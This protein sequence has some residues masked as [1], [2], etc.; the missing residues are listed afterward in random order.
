MPQ[1]SIRRVVWY[2]VN[3]RLTLSGDHAL[4]QP[5]SE[6]LNTG[7]LLKKIIAL[8][9]KARRKGLAGLNANKSDLVRLGMECA[10]SGNAV[11]NSYGVFHLAWLAA[12][13]SNWPA[14]VQCE[15]DEI[16]L[17]LKQTHGARLRFLIWAGM[18]GSAEDKSA[19]VAAGLLNKGPK[20]FVL[21]STDPAKLKA[22]LAGIE[23]RAGSLETGLKSTLV[24][25]MA[26]GMTSFEPVFNLERL[27]ALYDKLGIVSTP[28]FVY[29]T[30]P[31]SILDR[32]AGARGYRK[33][34]LQLDGG[35][36]TAGRHSSP[37]TMGSLLPLALAGVD[38][39][40][41]F[42]GAALAEADIA[43]AFQLAAFLHAHG[44]AGRDKVTLLASKPVSA[45]A[46][47]TKQ[48]FEESLG[49]SEDLG[50]KVVINETPRL[51]NYRPAKDARQD[52]I[53]LAIERKGDGS[54]DRQK[55]ATLKRSGYPLAHLVMDGIAPLSA[56]MQF[57]HYAVFGM[58]WLR[59]MNFVTQPSVELYKAIAQPIYEHGRVLGGT[60]RTPEW[61]A[62][63]RAIRQA[64]WR[65][66]T[67][68][69]DKLRIGVEAEGRDAP[70]IYA[71]LLS[72]LSVACAVEYGE[73][74]FFGDTRYDECGRAVRR[75]LERAAERVFRSVLKMPAD[76]YEGPAMNHSYHEM[77]IGHGRCFSTV[78]MSDQLDA[79]P[80]AGY[81]SG[82]HRAQFL[83]TQ[84]ALE[85]RARPVVSILLRDLSPASIDSL[86]GFFS[87]VAKRLK[88]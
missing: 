49:K 13:H 77:V 22:I 86:E 72:Q 19:Y 66:L 35:N 27:S 46:L 50:I 82:Y 17:R 18:G 10:A 14:L 37:L 47:W 78:V 70:A 9:S 84:M 54:L 48:N 85:Q 36:S 81:T 64:K 53:F 6:R 74:T 25:G 42:E 15:A 55:L 45:A 26:L 76:V 3:V 83:A 32:F 28:N 24:V 87:E 30:L 62:L 7:D 69:Y 79:L 51:A 71:A 43:Q 23:A 60:E 58:A 68:F 12:K 11:K 57:I 67:L 2:N 38:L 39:K 1:H 63:K 61:Q 8:D 59:R 88:R 5:A 20:V 73:L 44:E 65:G 16:K 80:E 56:Y 4:S 29:L 75:V 21:D 34:E 33:I 31:G 40:Q 41:W 52:R